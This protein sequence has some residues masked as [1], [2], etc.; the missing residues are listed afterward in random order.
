MNQK[1]RDRL[2][3]IIEELGALIEEEQEAFDN[4]PESFQYAERG[5]IMENNITEMESAKD[6]LEPLI[7]C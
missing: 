5:E 1:R 2:N 3:V 4:M 6:Y 7:E